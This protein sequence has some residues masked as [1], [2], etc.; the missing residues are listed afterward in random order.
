MYGGGTLLFYADEGQEYLDGKGVLNGVASRVWRH[1]RLGMHARDLNLLA[2]VLESG[3]S[4]G[5]LSDM[6][7]VTDEAP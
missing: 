3:T 5:S 2:D 7:A 4:F 6:P 1:Q